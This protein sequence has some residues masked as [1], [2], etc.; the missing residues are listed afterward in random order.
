MVVGFCRVWG[1]GVRRGLRSHAPRGRGM[2]DLTNRAAMNSAVR[3]DGEAHVGPDVTGGRGSVARV[4]RCHD[5]SSGL[6]FVGPTRGGRIS[7]CH[8]PW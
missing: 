4:E 7:T 5:V 6:A 2:C 3:I 8:R 1:A